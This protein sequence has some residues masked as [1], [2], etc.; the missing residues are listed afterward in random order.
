MGDAQGAEGAQQGTSEGDPPL[1]AS[2]HTL[3]AVGGL[4]FKL[5]HSDGLE[6]R[7]REIGDIATAG[8]TTLS[9]VLGFS[10]S[11]R[12]LV[13]SREDWP[14]YTSN[15]VFGMPHCIDGQTL[16]TAA[17]PPEFWE[18]VRSWVFAPVD[19]AGMDQLKALYGTRDGELDV[20][21]FSDLTVLH[22]L[23][24]IFHR[25]VPFDFPRAWMRELFANMAQYVAVAVGMPERLPQLLALP[26]AVHRPP[27]DLTYTSLDGLDLPVGTLGLG[28]FIWYQWHLLFA[29]R[30]IYERDGPATLRR[31]FDA[32]LKCCD[33]PLRDEDALPWLE[34]KAGPIV[35]GVMRSWPHTR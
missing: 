35:A 24:H 15:P 31:L 30:A 25:Q 32:S 1:T 27:E 6:A 18:G 22:E 2:M 20:R 19:A 8:L 23:G 14:R 33:R 29:A 34:Q 7:A 10:P 3:Q 17:D 21:P 9:N 4:T 28:N 26:R 12:V 5:E 16:V 11:L 13:L